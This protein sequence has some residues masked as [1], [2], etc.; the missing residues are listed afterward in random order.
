MA[1]QRL[2]PP[3]KPDDKKA[4][5]GELRDED[6]RRA[7]FASQ[8]LTTAGW[9]VTILGP[10][11]GVIIMVASG[12]TGADE[13]GPEEY[14]MLIQGGVIM[15][16]SAL[17]GLFMVMTSSFVRAH[18]NSQTQLINLMTKDVKEPKE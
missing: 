2:N 12:Q 8:F 14:A 9:V 17:S 11:I 13:M 6:R 5:S 1:G 3:L 18:L 4:T 10:V 7:I 16:V 15:V